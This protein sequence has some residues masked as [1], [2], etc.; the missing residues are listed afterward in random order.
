LK[1]KR[2]RFMVPVFFLLGLCFIAACGGGSN[3]V[4]FGTPANDAAKLTP[5]AAQLGMSKFE[6]HVVVLEL[7]YASEVTAS[8][9]LMRKFIFKG[10]DREY[11][12][13]MRRGAYEDIVSNF[14]EG[15]N[16][17]VYGT[18]RAPELDEKR[19]TIEVE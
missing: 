6:N 15:D 2:L 17:K 16:F 18:L 8:S 1:M 11:F 4:V 3:A 12:V 14:K 7:K 9:P 10:E 19:P 5:A 13:T